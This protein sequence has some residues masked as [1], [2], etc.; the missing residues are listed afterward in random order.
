M[1]LKDWRLHKGYT[2]EIAA[3]KFTRFLGGRR[4][5]QSLWSKWE[6]DYQKPNGKMQLNL[7]EF[8][9]GLVTHDDFY[10][11]EELLN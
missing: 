9:K 3:E 6:S 5:R 8:T 1:K 10:T 11:A 7:R 4:V 2:Q